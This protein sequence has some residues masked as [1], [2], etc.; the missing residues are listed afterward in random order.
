[1]KTLK[2]G[3]FT[4]SYFNDMPV[5][6]ALHSTKNG[7]TGF[8][9]HIHRHYE[10]IRVINGELSVQIGENNC[11]LTD[12]DI[13]FINSC[14][15]H[16]GRPISK[17]LEYEVIQLKKEFFER[18]KEDLPIIEDFLNENVKVESFFK[19]SDVCKIIEKISTFS[20]RDGKLIYIAKVF[21]LLDIIFTKH[22]VNETNARNDDEKNFEKD[23][24]NIMAYLDANF[25]EQITITE[26]ANKFGYNLSYLSRKFKNHIGVSPCAYLNKLRIKKSEVLLTKTEYSMEIISQK[27]GFESAN[28]FTRVFK[29][30]H[31]ISPTKFRN[32]RK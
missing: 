6:Y 12:N 18:I 11:I 31:K 29:K 8:P 2:K 3:T 21:E 5:I 23:V 30:R 15:S 13:C 24:S 17:D 27:C 25:T 32:L 9:T 20:N 26:V 19:D 1:M 4:A 16:F 28:Y 10:L 7:P 22:K 14:E